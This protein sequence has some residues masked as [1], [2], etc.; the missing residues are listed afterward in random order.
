MQ[1][2]TE[3]E[4]LYAKRVG[5]MAVYAP[6]QCC[7]QMLQALLVQKAERQGFSSPACSLASAVG[8]ITME[9]HRIKQGSLSFPKC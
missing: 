2:G 9:Q 6:F 3:P 1:G 8:R 4:R 5:C 7:S